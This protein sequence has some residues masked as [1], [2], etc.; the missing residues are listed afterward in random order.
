[1]C[2]DATIFCGGMYEMKTMFR[3]VMGFDVEIMMF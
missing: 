3:L 1:M 2:L